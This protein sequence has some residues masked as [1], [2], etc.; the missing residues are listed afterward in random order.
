MSLLDGGN[1]TVTV[2]PEVQDVDSE[3][4]PYTRP[5]TTGTTVLARV[6]PI[7]SG[8]RSAEDLTLGYDALTRYR[9]RID[10]RETVPLGPW[11]AVEWRGVLYDVLGEPELHT[12]S[13]R[14]FHVTA[15]LR[16]R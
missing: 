10:R 2:F 16:T 1:E 15:L 11:A 7:G 5:S 12:G 14:T 9:L 6:Q 3:G 8:V 4:N 13:A